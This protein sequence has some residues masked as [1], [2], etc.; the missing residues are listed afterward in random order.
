MSFAGLLDFRAPCSTHWPAPSGHPV[1]LAWNTRH[2]RQSQQRSQQWGGARCKRCHRSK[3]CRQALESPEGRDDEPVDIDQLAKRLSQEAEKVRQQQS[4][5]TDAH[6]PTEGEDLAAELAQT[7]R[8]TEAQA[9]RSTPAE[10]SSPF[11]YEV[12]CCTHLSLS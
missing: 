5:S 6:E 10:S 11:G 9:Q 7:V 4:R 2:L 8:D 3:T 1:R 12:S